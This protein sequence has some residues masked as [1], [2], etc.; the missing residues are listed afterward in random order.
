MLGLTVSFV[1]IT[2]SVAITTV[3]V[4]LVMTTLRTID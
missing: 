1:R 4:F 2:A 3:L